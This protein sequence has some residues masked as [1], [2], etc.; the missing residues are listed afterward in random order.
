MN[1]NGGIERNYGDESVARVVDFSFS[2]FFLESLG[3]YIP[4]VLSFSMSLL[5]SK[6]F[7]PSVLSRFSRPEGERYLFFHR[8]VHVHGKKEPASRSTLNPRPA[9][10]RIGR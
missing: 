5:L 2:L 1:I 6:P 7:Q 4:L 9:S 3:S 10:T 8:A